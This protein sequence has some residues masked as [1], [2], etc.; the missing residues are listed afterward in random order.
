MKKL[1]FT[2]LLM[3][4]LFFAA[5][6]NNANKKAEAA[7]VETE[8]TDSCCADKATKSCGD[9]AEKTGCGGEGGCGGSCD[10]KTKTEGEGGCGG[11][12]EHK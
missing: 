3:A 8:C 2:F 7:A 4:A 1:S 11:N 12:C 6:G 10:G 5:C 9:D